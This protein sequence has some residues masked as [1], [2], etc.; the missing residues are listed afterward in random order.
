MKENI[1]EEVWMDIP[2]YQGYY[3]A[4]NLGRIRS[5]DRT[6][7][8]SMGRKRFFKG[9][10]I[11][12][13]INKDGYRKVNLSKNG[14]RKNFTVSQVIAI[15]YLNHI[16]SGNTI[17]VDHINGDKLDDRLINL[18]LVTCRENLTI[19]FRSDRDSF[20][21]NFDGVHFNKAS[22]KWMANIRLNNKKIYLGQY[23]NEIDAAK[24]YQD[25]LYMIN[26]KVFQ[27]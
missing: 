10:I 3:Q 12:G 11:K 5:V 7:I 1:K 22:Q 9:K 15:T 27:F 20:S 18:R 19:C 2:D 25:M 6:F 14:K 26:N 23:D 24:A 4:S 16:P 8:D 21:S 13:V 17:V